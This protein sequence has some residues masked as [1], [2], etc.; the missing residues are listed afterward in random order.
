MLTGNSKL[1]PKQ[2]LFVS[3]YLI[4][5]NATKAAI[6][7]G[8]SATTAYSIGSENLTKPEIQQAIQEAQLDRQKRTEIT[9]DRVLKELALIAFIDIKD[10]FDEDGSLLPISKMPEDIRRAIGGMDYT[11]IGDVGGTSKIKLIDK[12]S[13]LELLG[14]HMKLFTDRTEISGPDGGPVQINYVPVGNKPK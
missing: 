11:T 5:L 3:E 4:D 2:T 7:A 12:K 8:Y 9:Q 13:A 10:A 14:K 1:T 6:R